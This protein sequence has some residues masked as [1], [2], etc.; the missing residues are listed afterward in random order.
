MFFYNALQRISPR[1][2]QRNVYP[3][4]SVPVTSGVEGVSEE[5]KI[6]Q[7]DLSFYKLQFSDTRSSWWI[8]AHTES[9]VVPGRFIRI[10]HANEKYE[11]TQM[12]Q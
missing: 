6:K 12:A 10:K 5:T 7:N 2:V 3:K 8:R 11:R 4:Y 9:S 1:Y